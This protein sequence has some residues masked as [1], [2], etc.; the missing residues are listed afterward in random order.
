MLIF[1]NKQI[2]QVVDILTPR[3][4]VFKHEQKQIVH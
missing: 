4:R 1:Y 3:I 2:K